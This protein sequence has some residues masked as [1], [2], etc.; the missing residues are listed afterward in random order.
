[1]GEKIKNIGKYKQ[2]MD[3]ELN[4]ASIQ[5]GDRWIH[6][7]NSKFRLCVSERDYIS[8]AIAILKAGRK[9]EA[10]KGGDNCGEY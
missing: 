3:I 6:I 1:M 9:F 8:A 7:Q 2:F 10:I 4:K 5:G